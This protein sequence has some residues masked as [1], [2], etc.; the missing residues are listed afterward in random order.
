MSNTELNADPAP[1]QSD[2]DYWERYDIP[3]DFESPIDSRALVLSCLSAEPQRVLELGCSTGVMTRVLAERG[4]HVT[5]VEIDPVAAG[6]AEPFADELLIGDLDRI[7]SDGRHLMSDLEPGR[8]DTLIAA[9]VLE[10]LRDPTGCLRRARDLVKPDGTFVLSIPNV[11]HADVRLAMLGGN[12]DYRDWGLLDRTH[13]QLF[14]L[15]SLVEM[16]R[17][18]GLAPVE[19]KRVSFPMGATEI[20]LDENLLEFGRRVLADDAEVETYQWIVTCRDAATAGGD[21]V[22]PTLPTSRPIVQQILAMMNEPVAR[23][24]SPAVP[25]EATPAPITARLKRVG[26]RLLRRVRTRLVA[27]FVPSRSAGGGR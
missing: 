22:W 12:F 3:I 1:D 8:F 10:H 20:E 6:F 11:A 23:A 18:V 19:W 7:E 13:A 24:E 25:I 14:T 2:R 16:I 27:S 15:E 9:D 4:H 26:G 17:A 21:A 5:A